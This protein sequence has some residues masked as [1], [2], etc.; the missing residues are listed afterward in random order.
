SL[1]PTAGTGVTLG[2]S[3]SGG[4]LGGKVKTVEPT[5]EY[6]HF[7]HLFA[8]KESRSRVEAGKART[9]GFRFLFWH[10]TSF[11]AQFDTNSLSFVGGTPLF[12][13]FFLGGEQDIRGF[14]VRGI[15]PSA[16]VVSTFSTRNI[17][18]QDL[19]GRV[20]KVRDPNNATNHSVAQSVLDQFTF[21]DKVNNQFPTFPTFIGGDTELLFNVEYRIPIIG[22][23]AFVPFVD[24]GSSFNLKGLS[25]QFERSEFIPNQT[26]G[27]VTLN[28]RGLIA[29]PREIRKATPPE[30]L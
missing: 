8:G 28:P 18:A 17:V 24:V 23:V 12:A 11:C 3:F 10:I 30:S 9:L 7:R 4:P 15:S 13:R 25:D 27:A 20:L 1:D 16:P 14:N 22:P 19:T 6:K 29:T 26:L 2:V 21:S 5:F